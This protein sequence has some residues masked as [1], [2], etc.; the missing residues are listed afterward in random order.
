MHAHNFSYP[1]SNGSELDTAILPKNS[2]RLRMMLDQQGS[3]VPEMV[4][5]HKRHEILL[6]VRGM[7]ERFEI[8][9]NT[10]LIIGRADPNSDTEVDIDLFPY[11]GVMRGISRLHAQLNLLRGGR[12]YITD[13]DSTN[14]TYL[15]GKRLEPYAPQPL[16]RGDE[17]VLG[18]LPIQILFK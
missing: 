9:E 18:R 15:R 8:E 5:L 13:M 3:P 6:M 2:S 14:G 10:S 4:G 11:G 1:H 17:L 16:R 12:L 7:T